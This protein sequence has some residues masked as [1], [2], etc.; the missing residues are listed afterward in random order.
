MFTFMEL[1]RFSLYI[2]IMII[3]IP[4]QLQFGVFF[5]PFPGFQTKAGKSY[6]S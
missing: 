4:M 1:T 6:G 3:K 2:N 5:A